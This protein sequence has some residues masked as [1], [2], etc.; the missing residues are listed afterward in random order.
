MHWCT[1]A[2]G[3]GRNSGVHGYER[4]L[5]RREVSLETRRVLELHDDVVWPVATFGLQGLHHAANEPLQAHPCRISLQVLYHDRLSRHNAHL[6]AGYQ[7]RSVRRRSRPATDKDLVRQES[8][9]E[10]V[11]PHAAVGSLPEPALSAGRYEAVRRVAEPPRKGAASHPEPAKG[12]PQRG[13]GDEEHRVGADVRGLAA[14]NNNGLVLPILGAPRARQLLRRQSAQHQLSHRRLERGDSQV[15]ARVLRAPVM[16]HK[17]IHS[18]IAKV[19]LAVEENNWARIL[20]RKQGGQHEHPMSTFKP[21]AAC[22]PRSEG[23]SAP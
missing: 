13:L 6:G 7:I 18:P 17:V 11:V 14:D 15:A 22:G 12:A 9:V 16:V 19:A 5:G 10:V 1:G 2:R 20:W 3:R 21:A 4:E 23:A 8:G